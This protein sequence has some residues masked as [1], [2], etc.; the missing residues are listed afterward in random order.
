[1]EHGF[2]V[3]GRLKRGLSERSLEEIHRVM[4]GVKKAAQEYGIRVV[5]YGFPY[6]VAEDF[7]VVYESEKGLVNFYNFAINTD[8]PYESPR[9]NQVAI[10]R[11]G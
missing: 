3:Y 2:I 5:M 10:P 1:M 9:T 11:P 8:L 4:E 7:V 6:G